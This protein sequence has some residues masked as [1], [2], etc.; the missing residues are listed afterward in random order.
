MIRKI[1]IAGL[2]ILLI[3]QP[4]AADATVSDVT[5][6]GGESKTVTID[7]GGADVQSTVV[8]APVEIT[9][10]SVHNS[11]FTFVVKAEHPDDKVEG[12]IFIKLADAGETVVDVTVVPFEKYKNS[13]QISQETKKDAQKWREFQDQWI[14]KRVDQKQTGEGVLTVYEQR[15]PHLGPVD[16]NGMPQGEWVQVPYNSSMQEPQ[17][18]YDSP[19]GAMAYMARQANRNDDFRR[20]TLML[21]GGIATTPFIFVFAV[22]PYWR[23]RRDKG[24]WPEIGGGL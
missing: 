15:I 23:K 19:S 1:A 12:K 6:L 11:T 13:Q 14:N 16:E 9:D 18:F 8:N 3:V 7:T 10:R 4:V 22:L 17:W 24:K 5:I 2:A 21:A 20:N